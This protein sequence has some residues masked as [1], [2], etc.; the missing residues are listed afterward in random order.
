MPNLSSRGREAAV[1]EYSSLPAQYYWLFFLFVY[2]YMQRDENVWY[3]FPI[4]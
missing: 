3:D 4:M 1:S 2:L